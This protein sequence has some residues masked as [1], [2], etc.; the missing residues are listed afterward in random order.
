VKLT[1]PR[2]A[3]RTCK[4]KLRL[5]AKRSGSRASKFSIKGGAKRTVRLRLSAAAAAAL[6]KPRA[7]ARLVSNEKGREGPVNRVA[8]VK[9]R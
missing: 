9:V 4:G 1:C 2:K 5:A 6:A 8:F 7:A 3:K